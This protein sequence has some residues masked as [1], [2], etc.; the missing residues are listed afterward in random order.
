M[1]ST[2]S[3][4]A[5]IR[6]LRTDQEDVAAIAAVIEATFGAALN[7][8][9]EQRSSGALPDRFV[10]VHFQ[11]LLSDPVGTVEQAYERM[12]CEF[13]G[14]HADRI[15]TYLAEKPRGKFGVHKY[16]AV[17]W[18]FDAEALRERL[19]PYVE[20]FGVTLEKDA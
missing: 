5:M 6:W 2:V 9:V 17:D 10:D 4:V 18:G 16:T 8:V 15:R 1:P 3:T 14:K 20:H 19:A 12:Q 7:G 13:T 11:D